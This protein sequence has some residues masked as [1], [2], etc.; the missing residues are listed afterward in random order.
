MELKP[1]LK[2][3]SVEKV[4]RR[5]ATELEGEFLSRLRQ[6]RIDLVKAREQIL[7]LEKGCDAAESAMERA[8]AYAPIL[9]KEY[10]CP[11]CFVRMGIS[12][13]LVESPGSSPPAEVM[14]CRKCGTH[15][16]MTADY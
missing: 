13:T 11:N 15:Y 12:G 6:F 7:F 16:Q 1:D 10:E 3:A 2:C 8:K 14:T 5:R 9:K 4:L